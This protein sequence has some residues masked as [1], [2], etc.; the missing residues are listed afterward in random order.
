MAVRTECETTILSGDVR[1][2]IIRTQ[3]VRKSADSI[4]VI[5]SV[6][7]LPPD[8]QAETD[9]TT[10][11]ERERPSERQTVRQTGRDRETC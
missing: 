2:P 11:R 6:Q 9:R 7:P 3:G 8:R 5:I 10:G 1:E 4:S